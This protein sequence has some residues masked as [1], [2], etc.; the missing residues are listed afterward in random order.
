MNFALRVILLS[1]ALLVPGASQSPKPK[2]SSQGGN[3]WALLIGINDYPGEIQDLRFA[4]DDARALK[5]VLISSAGFQEDHIR[6]LTDDGVGN[7]KATKQNILNSIEQSLAT[8][9][10]TNDQVIVFLAG[11]GI[12][13]GVGPE[14]KSYFLP[15]DITPQTPE[16]LE[17]S[18]IDL[19]ELGRKLSAL[20]ASQFTVFVDACREDPFPGRGLKC[21]QLTDVMT[22]GLR[23]RRLTA[24]QVNQTVVP[25]APTS[26]IFYACR[27]GERAYENLQLGHGVFTHFIMRGLRELA[28][29]PDGRVEAGLLAG[30]LRDNVKKWR[31]EAAKTNAIFGEQTPTMIATEVRGPVVV[32]YVTPMA[33]AAT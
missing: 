33:G 26:V 18:A 11:H 5:D 23:I 3:Q 12:V 8:Q 10:Q 30:Y 28:A 17:R 21:N 6:L 7:A 2:S 15:V 9:V 1:L 16:S 14:A 20:K 22:R 4:R 24:A 27:V 29:R 19:E 31:E 25:E 13:R 32:A